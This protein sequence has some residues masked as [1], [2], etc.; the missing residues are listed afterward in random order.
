MYERIEQEAT[1][2][3]PWAAREDNMMILYKEMSWWYWAVTELLL[4]VGLAGRPEAF[5]L[6]I[7]L[8]FAQLLHFRLR[9]GSFT[10]FPVQVRLVYAVVLLVCAWPP[11]SWLY[12]WPAIGTFTLVA[13]GY[14]FLARFLSLMPWNRRE[15]FT[16]RLAWRTFSAPPVKGNI[17][18]GLPAT[19]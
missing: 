8:S 6:A 9:E 14:C 12:W 17:M 18:Q 10:A 2:P 3:G 16:W 15:P 1:N 11:L 4:I 13:F 5:D 7:A 19:A